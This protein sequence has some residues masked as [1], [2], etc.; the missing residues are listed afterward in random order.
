MN[1][2]GHKERKLEVKEENNLKKVSEQL[3]R[4][5]PVAVSKSNKNGM[6][7]SDKTINHNSES[8]AWGKDSETSASLNISGIVAKCDNSGISSSNQIQNRI[9]EAADVKRK[10]SDA[11]PSSPKRRKVL[12]T[13]IDE[14]GREGITGLYFSR[15]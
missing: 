7:A 14:R 15:K 11:A 12:K 6:P 2:K 8:N 9:E 3:P 4:K 5:E 13:R 10:V 1:P